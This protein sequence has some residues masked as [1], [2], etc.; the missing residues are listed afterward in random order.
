MAPR[1]DPAC[2]RRPRGR[3]SPTCSGSINSRSMSPSTRCC[4]RGPRVYLSCLSSRPCPSAQGQSPP[5]PT[6]KTILDFLNGRIPGWFDTAL[7][8]VDV[9][10]V[11]AGHLLAAERGAARAFLC[12]RRREHGATPDP[13]RACGRHRPSPG[14]DQGPR[15]FALVAGYASGLIEGRLLRREPSIPLKA[16][17]WPRPE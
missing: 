7:N 2:R 12:S 17:G 3:A 6:G 4:G 13:R 5:T 9:D 16:R 1:S 11:A 8:V 10:D 15:R 14:G